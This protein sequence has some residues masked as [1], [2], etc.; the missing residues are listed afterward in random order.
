MANVQDLIIWD[1][2]S[3]ITMFLS[4]SLGVVRKISL[5]AEDNIFFAFEGGVLIFLRLDLCRIT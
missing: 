1:T 3:G 4:F 5:F 2:L